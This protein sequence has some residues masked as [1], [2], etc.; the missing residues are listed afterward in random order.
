MSLNGVTGDRRTPTRP[1]PIA[2]DGREDFEQQAR[3]VFLA[4]AIGIAALVGRRT[5]EL[6]DQV[7]VAGMDLDAVETGRHRIFRR[8][9]EAGDEPGISAV[10]SARGVT[11]SCMPVNVTACPAGRSAEGATGVAPSG[12]RSGCEMR[13]TCQSW[14]A[15]LPPAACT[16][17]VTFFQPAICSAVWMPGVR[18]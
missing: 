14:M 18:G 17:S 16:A 15:I 5:Q 13:P 4:A 7:A 2:A 6:V 10:S 12:C 3:P 8:L 1:L 9:H 11:Y